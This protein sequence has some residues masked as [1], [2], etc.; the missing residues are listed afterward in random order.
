MSDE[1]IKVVREA[2][3]E[4]LA[5][6][7]SK[8]STIQNTLNADIKNI[9]ENVSDH[10]KRLKKVEKTT[11]NNNNE[12][13]SLTTQIELLKQDR[14]RNNLRFTGLPQEAFAN[15]IKTF[16]QIS[17]A[18]QLSLIPS[19]FTAYGDR[20]KSSIIVTYYSNTHKRLVMDKMR[21]KKSLLVEEV[22]PGIKSNS[23]VYANDHL[24]PHF[25]KLFQLAWNA[26]KNGELFSASS[27]GGRIKIR[28]CESDQPKIVDTEQEL[29]DFIGTVN[30]AKADQPERS[31]NTSQIEE[32]TSSNQGRYLINNRG[33]GQQHRTVRP[34]IGPT[35][36][37]QQYKEHP[38]TSRQGKRD[39]KYLSSPEEKDFVG[40][41]ISNRRGKKQRA[42]NNY[43]SNHNR[44]P[45]AH[46][47]H[48]Y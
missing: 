14:L 1:L 18:L 33:I 34:R 3:K 31:Q 38:Q 8:I 27:I 40:K 6:T 41:N 28:K 39:N 23:Q 46:S 20:N 7:N 9:R 22:F 30:E 21:E 13:A 48:Q 36:N 29:L 35:Y 42:S 37:K 32:K 26:K 11:S 5:E 2:L 47:S 16:L 19:D 44:Y 4:E 17:N 15:P 10:D 12:I 45:N 24:T 25:A 43:T